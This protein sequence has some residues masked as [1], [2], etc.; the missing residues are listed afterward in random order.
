M[1]KR[2]KA[3]SIHTAARHAWTRTPARN[4]VS[5]SIYIHLSGSN[6]IP[7]ILSLATVPSWPWG[8]L[9]ITTTAHWQ[10]FAPTAA[11]WLDEWPWTVAWSKSSAHAL[12]PALA[13]S[14]LNFLWAI[15]LQQFKMGLRA[16]PDQC[17]HANIGSK[18]K[19]CTT[20]E[21]CW[22]N[23]VMAA[24]FLRKWFS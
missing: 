9:W 11:D 22:C 18:M 14:A 1:P 13:E 17:L 4:S 8:R 6:P 7:C 19:A 2:P 10:P 5:K 12:L 23:K 20:I 16:V 15:K 21:E 3:N 24:I